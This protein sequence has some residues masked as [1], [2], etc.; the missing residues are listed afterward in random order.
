MISSKLLLHICSVRWPPSLTDTFNAAPH[1]QGLLG[2]CRIGEFWKSS[3]IGAGRNICPLLRFADGPQTSKSAMGP[4]VDLY[5]E[6]IDTPGAEQAGLSELLLLPLTENI[7]FRVE[8]DHLS[9]ISYTFND[10]NRLTGEP[11]DVSYALQDDTADGNDWPRAVQGADELGLVQIIW[12]K[13]Q[14]DSVRIVLR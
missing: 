14:S 2:V 12:S 4:V 10:H 1:S 11:S 3:E 5:L 7:G 9:A 8:S 13:G 6:S